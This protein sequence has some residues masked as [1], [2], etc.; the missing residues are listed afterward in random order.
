MAYTV[1]KISELSGVTIRALH[2][3]EEVGLLRPAYHGSNGYRYY[4][5]KELLQLQQILFFK[6]L[7]FSLKQIRKVLGKS[8]FDQ[9]AALHS[10]RQAL[11]K[12]WERTGRLIETIDKTIQHLQGKKKM[13]QEEMYEGFTTKEKQA[14][15][16]EYLK[17]RFGEDHPSFAEC[18]KNSKGWTKEDSEKARKEGDANFKE[19]AK[20]KE[21]QFSP[22]SPEVQ[23]IVLKIYNWV[24]QFWTP[25]KESFP[26]LGQMYTELE[27]KKFFGKYDPHHPQLAMFVA[28][29]MKF[30]AETKL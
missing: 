2:F 10:H 17:N 4:E 6:E 11:S 8:D 21:K 23:T 14:E 3:Y 15:Y 30:F 24:K 20:L 18:E 1:K 13:K 22:S 28:E 19:L 12:E 16:V 5:E 29:G 7:G 27:W 25:D 9:L 26:A